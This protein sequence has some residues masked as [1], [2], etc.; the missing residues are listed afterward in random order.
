[1][2]IETATVTATAG[3]STVSAQS[4]QYKDGTAHC[5]ASGTITVTKGAAPKVEVD[6]QLK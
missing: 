6:Y 5:Q 2:P 4:P 1:M 3:T